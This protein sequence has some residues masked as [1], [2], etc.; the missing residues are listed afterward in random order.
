MRTDTRY[1]PGARLLNVKPPLLSVV[2]LCVAPV[3][4]L[5]NVT[6]APSIPAPVRRPVNVPPDCVEFCVVVCLCVC[7]CVC[8]N[9]NV[10]IV[11]NDSTSPAKTDLRTID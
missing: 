3:A 9:A 1:V 6:V 11:H 7:V 10:T 2:A 5:V 4:L 8:E